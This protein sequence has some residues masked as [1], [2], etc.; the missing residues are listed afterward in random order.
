MSS[1]TSASADALRIWTDGQIIDD[2]MAGQRSQDDTLH[3]ASC[4]GPT[5]L[6][7]L[8][9]FSPDTHAS[10]TDS[11]WGSSGNGGHVPW[12]NPRAALVAVASFV[13]FCSLQQRWLRLDGR[14]GSSARRFHGAAQA[15]RGDCQKTINHI[16][17]RRAGVHRISVG[18]L[19]AGVSVLSF[20]ASCFPCFSCFSC[21][22]FY[23][24]F[25]LFLFLHPAFARVVW[26]CVCPG[27]GGDEDQ[28]RIE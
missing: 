19:L 24:F 17:N 16:S 5:R 18:R 23:L 10:E 14:K 8:L 25:F 3:S 28:G 11:W 6:P 27:G 1:P 7:F 13:A 22:F 4:E 2:V 15:F 21:F 26:G 9:Q 20:S 12:E